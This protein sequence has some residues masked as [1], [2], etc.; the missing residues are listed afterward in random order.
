MKL[1]VGLTFIIEELFV[2][3]MKHIC[4]IS[5]LC[6]VKHSD[7]VLC[8][9]LPS[10]W[11]FNEKSIKCYWHLTSVLEIEEMSSSLVAVND[12]V[13]DRVVTPVVLIARV[14]FPQFK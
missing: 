13:S 6:L 1:V 3:E 5:R 9:L 8:R 11:V 12:F 10:F 2:I 4:K 14:S 7:E